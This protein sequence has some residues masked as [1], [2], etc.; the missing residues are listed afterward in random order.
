[1]TFFLRLFLSS[2]IV[3]ASALSWLNNNKVFIHTH[4][5]TT[6]IFHPFVLTAGGAQGP[7]M[8]KVY[9]LLRHKAAPDDVEEAKKDETIQ[10]QIT[11]GVILLRYA[12]N[13]AKVIGESA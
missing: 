11:L 5:C 9:E 4:T 6:P 2:D 7:T 1:M 10:L 8:I 13:M 12:A 3:F